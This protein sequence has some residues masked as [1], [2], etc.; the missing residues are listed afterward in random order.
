VHYF[1][2]TEEK[3]EQAISRIF[4]SRL[5]L[6]FSLPPEHVLPRSS[7]ATYNSLHYVSIPCVQMRFLAHGLCSFTNW[8][9]PK[10]NSKPFLS[11]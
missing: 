5:I 1:V 9:E 8:V 11:L 3:Y 7:M 2:I 6:I 10:H 4:V